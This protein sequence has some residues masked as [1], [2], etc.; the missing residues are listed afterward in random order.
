MPTQRRAQNRFSWVL[1][2][3]R[4]TKFDKAILALFNTIEVGPTLARSSASSEYSRQDLPG[5]HRPSM[6]SL[7]ALRSPGIILILLAISTTVTSTQLSWH[8]SQGRTISNVYAL[9]QAWNIVSEDNACFLLI[10]PAAIYLEDLYHSLLT[11]ALTTRKRET[12]IVVFSSQLLQLAITCHQSVIPWILVQNYARRM[13]DLTRSGYTGRYLTLIRHPS[14]GTEVMMALD[15]LDE[16]VRG[17]QGRSYIGR[18]KLRCEFR[19][20]WNCFLK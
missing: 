9:G 5:N 13:L 19:D 11:Y 16:L 17:V 7:Q 1:T 10:V 14:T 4:V 8:S 3:G 18:K 12:N 15:V 20:S 6:G 2:S